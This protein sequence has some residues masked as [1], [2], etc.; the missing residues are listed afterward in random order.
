MEGA[1]HTGTDK[2][3]WN[4][5]EESNTFLVKILVL[6]LIELYLATLVLLDSLKWKRAVPMTLVIL[7][8]CLI[9]GSCLMVV[10]KF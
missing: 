9:L 2:I 8:S 1:D 4:Q 3:T 6:T 10:F 5:P 7:E